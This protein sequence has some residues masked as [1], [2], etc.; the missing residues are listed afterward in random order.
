MDT[1]KN[2]TQNKGKVDV[3]SK[4]DSATYSPTLVYVQNNF[5]SGVKLVCDLFLRASEE[6]GIERDL[7]VECAPA[8]QL[9]LGF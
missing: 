8:T 6:D 5:V 2:T 9:I 7:I 1:D 3:N 4:L